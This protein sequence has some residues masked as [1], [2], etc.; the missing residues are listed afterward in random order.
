[1]RELTLQTIRPLIRRALQEDAASWDLTSRATIPPTC[2]LSAKIIA[3]TSGILAGVDVAVWTFQDVDSTLQCKVIRRDG[4]VLTD[5]ATILTVK[6]RARSVFAAERT[7]LNMLGHLSGVATLTQQFVK[8][9]RSTRA[10]ILDTRKTLP[11]LRELQ[12]YAVRVG[13]GDNHRMGLH[14]AILIKTNHVRAYSVQRIADRQQAETGIEELVRKAKRQA[15][16][17]IVEVEVRN[18]KEFQAALNAGPN[19]I[20]L[21]NWRIQD[22]RKA[23]ALRRSYTLSAKRCTL[24]V[25]GGITL[26]NV[27]AIAKTGVDRISVGRLTHSAPSLDLCLEVIP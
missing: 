26:A 25:S 12:K 4:T 9:V 14:E 5:G 11:G 20:L 18:M 7:A 17:R 13:G 6:G 1:M 24:E 15:G 10:K 3:K 21:D 22:I 27:R 16:R 19:M 8:R 2:E 23:V